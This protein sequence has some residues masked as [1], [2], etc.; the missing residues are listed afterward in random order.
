MSTFSTIDAWLSYLE[1]IH[2]VRIDMGLTRVGLIKNLLNIKFSCPIF[3]VGG[4][5]GKGSTCIFL[6]TILI[7]GGYNVGCHV[8]PHLLKFNERAR[9]NGKNVTDDEL[10]EHFEAVESA[11]LSFINPISLTYFEF[12]TLAILNLFSSHRLDVVILEVGLGGRFDAINIIDTDCAIITSID[13]D[14]TNYL[15]NT[16]DAI[17]VEK[18][19]I[20]RAGKPAICGDLN[21]PCK[22]IEY[23]EN[24]GADLWLIRRD[25]RIEANLGKRE[26]WT[27]IGRSRCYT[28]LTYPM[29]IGS[30]QLINASVAIAALEA[31]YDRLPISIQ[32]IQLG[33]SSAKLPGR[34][35]VLPGKPIVIL[36][37][38]HN[39]KAIATLVHNF[40]DIGYFTHTHAVF[41]V[42]YDKDISGII[43]NMKNDVDYWYVTNLPSTRAATAEQLK[44]A[45]QQSGIDNRQ[46]K[47]VTQFSST[48]EAFRYAIKNAS[49]NDKIIVTGSFHTVSGVMELF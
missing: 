18:A 21:T 27:Y 9:L 16:R 5:N 4:T 24:F 34:F 19:G 29:L 3:T 47:K 48:A 39:P 15:G 46:T 6:E 11:R 14:H 13:I 17:A 41:G 32:D 43:Q 40:I 1:T 10:L 25:F 20:F 31:L 12:T 45:L 7:H 28:E 37:V 30:N 33:V 35:Q 2:P 42:M 26:K 38:A 8:S 49:N 23:A 44:I 22:L 36:D